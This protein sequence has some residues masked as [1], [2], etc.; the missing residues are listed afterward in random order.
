MHFCRELIPVVSSRKASFAFLARSTRPNRLFSVVTIIVFSFSPPIQSVKYPLSQR[1]KT[2]D[3]C[4]SLFSCIN[5]VVCRLETVFQF[6]RPV[7]VF[8]SS[9]ASCQSH[10]GLIIHR[11]TDLLINLTERFAFTFEGENS[12]PTNCDHPNHCAAK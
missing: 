4:V 10:S 11:A 2:E 7:A 12:R 3:A 9:P 8:N 5:T 6:A 1:S